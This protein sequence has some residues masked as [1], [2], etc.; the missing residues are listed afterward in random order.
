MTNDNWLTAI[1]T[2]LDQRN[3]HIY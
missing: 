3:G 1:F 2:L